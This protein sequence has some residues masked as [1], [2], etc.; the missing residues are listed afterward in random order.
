MTEFEYRNRLNQEIARRTHMQRELEKALEENRLLRQQIALLQQKN[1]RIHQET[2]NYIASLKET[3]NRF[4]ERIDILESENE[5][6]Q[7]LLEEI[8][9]GKLK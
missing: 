2:L 5:R 4:Q 1:D 8:G 3:E 7:D 6:F 9:Y